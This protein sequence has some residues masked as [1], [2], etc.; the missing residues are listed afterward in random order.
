[1]TSPTTTSP[2]RLHRHGRFGLAVPRRWQFQ[3]RPRETDLLLRD[4]KT[5]GL[6]VYEINHNQLSGAASIGTVGLD[7]QYRRIRSRVAQR[8]YRRIRGLQHCQHSD[9]SSRALG[10]GRIGS[11]AWRFR[12]R[13]ANRIDSIRK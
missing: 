11:A 6:E 1:M 4:S 2:A 12:R 5:G 10:C 3:R 13:T 9:L 7:W 8:Q